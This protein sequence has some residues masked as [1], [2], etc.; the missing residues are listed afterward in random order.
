MISHYA[1][2]QIKAQWWSRIPLVSS[3]F[4]YFLSNET[5]NGYKTSFGYT[6]QVW[7]ASSS[8]VFKPIGVERAMLVSPPVVTGTVWQSGLLPGQNGLLQPARPG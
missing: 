6:A 8:S 1:E 2:D 5:L 4:G 3:L 7:K